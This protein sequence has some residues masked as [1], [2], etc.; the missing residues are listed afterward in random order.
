MKVIT[1]LLVMFAITTACA[2]T[3]KPHALAD[4]WELVGEVVNEPGYH[5]WGCSPMQTKDGTTHLFAARWPKKAAFVP[6]WHT[7]CE[8]ARY[9]AD[10]PEGPFTFAEVVVK[11]SETEQRK[12]QAPHNPNIQRAGKK[13][14]L[15]YIV[16]SGEPFPASQTIEMLI[17]DSIEGPW[18]PANGDASKP[19]L[20]PPEDPAIWCYKSRVGVNNPALLPMPDGTFHLYF[21][22]KFH[23]GGPSK[24]GLAIAQQIE[25]PFVI[26]P[27]P[28]TA[29]K[30]HIE[31][32]YA[33]I[34]N[35]HVC[36]LTT[37]NSGMLEKGGGLL[38]VSKDGKKFDQA[39][40][41]FHHFKNHF[42]PNGIP[43]N[44]KH[45]YGRSS[46]NERPQVLVIDGEP[47]Y[48]YAPSGTALDGSDGTN[49]YLFKRKGSKK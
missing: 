11:G 40:G 33:F 8:I 21:K 23:T 38:W 9:V 24:M 22:G 36:L 3:Q 43:E 44:A 2:V 14:V 45:H 25:G 39:L 47:A 7:H 42:F 32:G 41:G 10:K 12:S 13:F 48:L 46:K 15:T 4:E 19:M 17:A 49:N 5:V 29:N 26:Q 37:D 34:W 30:S 27:D 35:R 31:D 6:G 1:L 20:A 16:N 28:V 18:K